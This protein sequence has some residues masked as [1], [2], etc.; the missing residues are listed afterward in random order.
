MILKVMVILGEALL[1]FSLNNFFSHFL[2]RPCHKFNNFWFL[3]KFNAI[4]FFVYHFHDTHC[5]F[6]WIENISKCSDLLL[7]PILGLIGQDLWTI[8]SPKTLCTPTQMYRLPVLCMVLLRIGNTKY[9][10]IFF[11]TCFAVL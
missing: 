9:V 4:I 8:G 5:Q 6:L 11:P 3:F 10:S 7:M 2:C 1:V